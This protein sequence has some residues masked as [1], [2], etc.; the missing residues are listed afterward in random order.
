MARYSALESDLGGRFPEKSCASAREARATTRR[1]LDAH[2][3]TD[4]TLR[5]TGFGELTPCALVPDL[6][7]VNGVATIRGG[8]RPELIAAVAKGL[9]QASHCG[10]E[11]ALL[12]DVRAALG[13]AGFGDWRV[14]V[15]H[16]LTE[17]WPCVAGF[18]EVPAEKTIVLV[19]HASR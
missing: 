18:N 11:S 2:G 12:A 4:W 15:D 6:D 16:P 17:R 1:A 7:P 19:G 8:V 13:A 9:E 14:R 10:P 3:Y 5:S